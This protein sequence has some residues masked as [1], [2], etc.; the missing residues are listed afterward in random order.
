MVAIRRLLDPCRGGACRLGLLVM[1]TLAACSDSGSGGGTG[2]PTPAQP[3]AACGGGETGRCIVLEPSANDR[4][5]LLSVLI[6]AQEGD[7][8]VLKAGFYDVRGQ[9]S[10]D[11]PGVSI[12]GEGMDRTILSFKNQTSGGEGLLVTA[13]RFTIEDLA[14]EDGP[15]DQLKIF[16]ADDVTIRRV[17]VEWTDGPSADNG[18][19]GLYP[20]QCRNV[21]IEDSVVIG[22]S[23]AGVYVGQSKNIVVRRNRAAYNVA[24][25]EIENSQDADV[26]ENDA[27]KNT[28]GILVFNLPGLPVKDGR[29]TRI[30]RNRI[31]DNSTPNFAPPGNIVGAV[32]DGTGVM[33]MANDDVE[34]FDNDIEGNGSFG[35]LAISFRT[36]QLIG[37][38]RADDPQ[39]DP[40]SE[41]IHIHGNRFT[42]NGTDPDPETADLVRPLLGLPASAALPT[43]V[44]D[45]DVDAGKLVGG[46]LPTELRTCVP[47]PVPSFANLDAG[48]GFAGATTDSAAFQCALAPVPPADFEGTVLGEL[49]SGLLPTVLPPGSN[50]DEET[51]CLVTGGGAVNVD[52][53]DLTCDLLSSYR[54]FKGDGSTQEP[55]DGVVPFDLNTQL[56]SDYAHKRRFVY[57]PEGQAAQYRAATAF[58]FPVGSVI[59]KTFSYRADERDPSIG[60]RLIETRLLLRRADRWVAV[61]YRWNDAQTDAVLRLVGDD[62]P[63]AWLD[64]DGVERALTFHVPDANQCK[65]CHAE[66]TPFVTPL[67]PKA[68]NLNK[69]FAYEDGEENQLTHWTRL[70]ILTGA[71]SPDVAPRAAVF[72]D[73]S[74]GSLDERAR[75]YLDVNCSS[76]HNRGG[77]ARTSGLYLTIDEQDPTALGIC[78][79]P[80]AAG[81]GSGD[82]RYDIDPGHPERSIL[83]SRMEST[84]AG[85]AMPELGRA[86]VHGQAIEVLNDWIR[87]MPGSCD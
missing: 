22:A 46:E 66:V 52:P 78:K 31:F 62:V 47:E 5:A 35:V 54:L 4:E 21:L 63:V 33:L 84:Q 55:N 82:R 18:A 19:Y 44:T 50:P 41:G 6:D 40:Y 23:D 25:I 64:A 16:G 77:L 38:F 42:D 49:P 32:P 60:E 81:G 48:N 3:A 13:D 67:G 74:S 2:G 80:V 9:L 76:C 14:F 1:L 71:P 70:G 39:F 87:A 75:T 27:T 29:R 11:V 37:G 73:P 15:G 51:R 69:V 72:D 30:F 36:A 8:I 26:Y 65:E 68:R 20:V 45:G 17:R 28:G 61:T 34:V 83:T 56:F 58:E 53:A 59:V 7:V 57:V 85:V 10:L 43:V 24:G 86:L 12:R 79:S